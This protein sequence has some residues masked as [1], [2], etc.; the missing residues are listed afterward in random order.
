MT[1]KENKYE[2]KNIVGQDIND[3]LEKNYMPYA[4]SVIVSRAIPEIDG[5]K[6]S[7]RKLLYTMYKM[8]LLTG[9]RIKSADVVGQT[10]ALNPHGDIAIYETL[11][12]LTRGNAALLHPF[13]DSKGNFG[14]QYSRDMAYAAARY[15]EVKLDE[16]C[17][18]VFRDIEKDTV[19]F[20]DNYNGTTKEPVL[21]PTTFPNLLV[22]AN[23]GIAVGMASSMPG[24]NLAEVCNLTVAYIKNNA[25]D[26]KKYLTGPDFST[27][28]QLIYNEKELDNIYETGRGGVK[29][30]AKYRYDKKN[31]VIEVYEIPYSTTVEAIIDNIAALVK[32]GKLRES[33]DVRD[34]T[35]LKGLKIA[36]D[37]RRNANVEHLMHRLYQMTA[38]SDSFSCNFNFLI[39]GK[40]RT[41]GVREILE[42]WL[43]F[44]IG[45]ISRTAR[46]DLKKK[47]DRLHLLEGLSKILLDIDRAIK[48]IRGTE[49]DALVIPNLMKGFGIDELQAEFVAEIKLRNLNKQYILKQT[50][51]K[52]TLISEIA[53][54][55]EILENPEKVNAIIIKQLKDTAKKYGKPRMT[56]VITADETPVLPDDTFIDDYPLKLYLTAHNY[57]KKI[58]CASLRASA[59]QYL[60][61]DDVI[62][63]E[64]DG[65]NKSDVLFFSNK[66]NAYK[67]KA[68]ELPDCKASGLGEYLTNLLKLPEDERIV[69]ITATLNYAGNLLFAFENGKFAKI[70]LDGYKTVT[71]R[72]RLINAYSDKSP[73]VF[74]CFISQDTDIVAIR[75]DSKAALFNSALIE[76]K[77]A[78]NSGGVQVFGLSKGSKITGAMLACDFLSDD[79]EYYRIQKIPQRGHFI[80][81]NDKN[82]NGLPSQIRLW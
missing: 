10:M 67:A 28:G 82:A 41:M 81:E 43:V 16:I 78:K 21:F 73:L 59:E 36:I 80:T 63:R 49:E 19:D 34:E 57:F 8:G 62:V 22:T 45:V 30:R 6:P 69:F 31:S 61:D 71:N 46:F 70:A 40:P 1:S 2:S 29:V 51:D 24:F 44:R 53:E 66:F 38:L 47:R 64:C 7:H 75:S 48:I 25:C 35:D 54:L 12:R 39:D 14:K 60:K 11:V 74:A 3:T 56:E 37:V 17:A 9:R 79:I 15:T 42:E 65:T 4:M 13:I 52:D 26:I 68:Y 23:Q 5:F 50:G 27:G 76:T 18:E 55:N 32:A 58:S 77:A 72:K 20:I 33:T